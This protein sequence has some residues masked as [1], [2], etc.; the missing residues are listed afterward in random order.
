[1]S[2]SLEVVVALWFSG[3]ISGQAFASG[4]LR[5]KFSPLPA[6]QSQFNLE[7]VPHLSKYFFDRT[8]RLI[9]ALQSPMTHR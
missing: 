6:A 1:M 7:V 9:A 2:G 8:T 5:L 3:K 4:A